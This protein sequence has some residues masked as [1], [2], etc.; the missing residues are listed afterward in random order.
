MILFVMSTSVVRA[1]LIL[2]IGLV[3]AQ[4]T[5]QATCFKCCGKV[6][7]DALFFHRG[8]S[9]GGEGNC[10]S[11]Q[12][13]NSRGNTGGCC[14]SDSDRFV[15]QCGANTSEPYWECQNPTYH[16]CLPEWS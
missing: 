2:F 14:W 5:A 6:Y 3:T 8:C 4:L 16:Y 11:T 12:C 7:G 9:G 1:L 15:D 10:H 13:P